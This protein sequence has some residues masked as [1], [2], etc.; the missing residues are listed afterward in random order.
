MPQMSEIK[1]EYN[2]AGCTYNLSQVLLYDIIFF[3]LVSELG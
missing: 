2:V 3:V 1:I